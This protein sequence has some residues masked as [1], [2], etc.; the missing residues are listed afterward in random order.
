MSDQQRKQA[1]PYPSFLACLDLNTADH[2]AKE[3]F[4]SLSRLILTLG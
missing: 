3:Y 1:F 4:A 2:G